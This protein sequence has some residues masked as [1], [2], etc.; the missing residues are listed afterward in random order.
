MAPAGAGTPTKKFPAHA[1]L[2]GSSIITLK[3]ASRSPVQIANTMAAIQ[4]ALPS[5]CSAQKYRISAGATPKF[6]KSARLSS[7][8]PK[9]E[10]PLSMR[11]TRPSMPSSVAANTIAATAHSSLASI[12]SRIAVRPAQSAS[13]VIRFGTSVRTGIW[14]KRRRFCGGRV[15]SNGVVSMSP[16]IAGDSWRRHGS[17]ISSSHGK[18]LAHPEGEL[19]GRCPQVRDHGLAR[20][21]GLPL[22][23]QRPRAFRQ[24]DIDARAEPDHADALAGTHARALA[25]E[26]DNA[27][28][29]QS[30]D[31]HDDDARRAGADEEGIA[32]VVLAR[33]VEVGVDEGARLVDDLLDP[34][35]GGAAI[36]VT[37]EHVHEDRD[38]R[39]GALAEIE[40]RRR[41]RVDDLAH[42][43][44]GGRDHQALARRRHPVGIAE[45]QR[46]PDCHDGADPA[47]RRPEPEQK[48]ARERKDADERQSFAMDRNDLPSDRRDN[49]HAHSAA[50]ILATSTGFAVSSTGLGTSSTCGGLRFGAITSSPISASFSR[51]AS[52]S[53]WRFHMLA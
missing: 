24:V 27:P 12:A 9:R 51:A 22:R 15:G 33:L 20:D 6:T 7:S 30:C 31:L 39:Q 35:G 26:G 17:A 42:A 52:A 44:V 13:S 5:S 23:H 49:R 41:H 3:R 48:Q 45:E 40:L 2:F 18:R 29:D 46:A 28:C 50:W 19:P 32:F 16:N 8:A 4:P 43:A 38:A 36:D 10:V 14:R 25:R 37:V 47:E 1:G 53:R 34:A 11:A 21:R